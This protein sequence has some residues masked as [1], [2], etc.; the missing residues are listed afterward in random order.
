M[1]VNGIFAP[2]IEIPD[3]VSQ[4]NYSFQVIFKPFEGRGPNKNKFAKYRFGLSDSDVTNGG[5]SGNIG[6]TAP[7][8]ELSKYILP[9]VK[10]VQ[11]QSTPTPENFCFR[12]LQ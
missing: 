12:T 7:V 2:D 5:N 8:T 11:A 9:S 3:G 10:F 6:D 1:S 4:V